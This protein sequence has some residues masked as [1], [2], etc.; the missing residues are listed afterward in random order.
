MT[1]RV[2]HASQELTTEQVARQHA[3]DQLQAAL[4]QIHFLTSRVRQAEAA[5]AAGARAS[6]T[7]GGRKAPKRRHAWSPGA[8]TRRRP[9]SSRPGGTR[10]DAAT[11]GPYATPQQGGVG[12]SDG[13]RPQARS[14]TTHRRRS[15]TGR[16]HSR[17]AS[18]GL[19]TM[20][21]PTLP[22]SLRTP[23]QAAQ[24]GYD[25]AAAT[26]HPGGSN[27]SEN[28]GGGDSGGEAPAAMPMPD[29]GQLESIIRAQV[30]AARGATRETALLWV[31][32]A[33]VRT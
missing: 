27:G 26:P 19:A 30:R 1:S 17:P 11:P 8:T 12:H 6:N 21:R 7:G 22:P 16:H 15:R 29:V 9:A 4:T 23:S 2:V 24:H 32:L 31:A 20:A 14:A 3:E 33:T 13:T 28:G 10:R 5:A 25:K 18:A